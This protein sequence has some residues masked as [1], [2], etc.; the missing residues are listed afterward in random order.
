MSQNAYKTI[1]KTRGIEDRATRL[2]NPGLQLQSRGQEAEVP[3]TQ[4]SQGFRKLLWM[5]WVLY[6]PQRGGWKWNMKHGHLKM[7]V[8]IGHELT[9]IAATGRRLCLPYTSLSKYISLIDY[10]LHPEFH[11][12][13]PGFWLLQ[14]GTKHRKDFKWMIINNTGLSS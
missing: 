11:T 2:S 4:K 9:T 7:H 14:C 3:G 1:W 5:L 10:Q 12:K 6:S 8:C 13:F